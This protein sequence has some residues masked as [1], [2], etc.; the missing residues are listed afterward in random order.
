MIPAIFFYFL[1]SGSILAMAMLGHVGLWIWFYNR[2]NA[3]GLKRK[4]VKRTEKA[5]VLACGL[6]P[7]VLLLVEVQFNEKFFCESVQSNDCEK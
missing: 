4:T 1:M 3:T 5:L 6:I 7:M 2:I